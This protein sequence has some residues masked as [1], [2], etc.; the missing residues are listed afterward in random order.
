MY[1][2]ACALTLKCIRG[3]NV[4]GW[5]YFGTKKFI[6]INLCTN[7]LLNQKLHWT[8]KIF[9]GFDTIEMKLIILRKG[10]HIYLALCLTLF[11]GFL[12][13]Q[14]V[15]VFVFFYNITQQSYNSEHGCSDFTCCWLRNSWVI[16]NKRE[17]CFDCR[18][19]KV[20]C[21]ISSRRPR[22]GPETYI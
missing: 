13:T 19:I 9:M 2:L 12:V 1:I 18:W 5:K 17:G 20:I 8:K 10:N 14:S 16:K 6:N 15:C 3:I 11:F 21:C 22:R 7:Q 4:F